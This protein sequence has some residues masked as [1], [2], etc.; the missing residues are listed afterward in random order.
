MRIE[1]H[2]DVE[3][4][5]VFWVSSCDVSQLHTLN[6][7]RRSTYYIYNIFNTNEIMWQVRMH[8]DF[9]NDNEDDLHNEQA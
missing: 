5:G 2:A 9:I 8:T 7:T 4:C 3:L 1:L 6:K